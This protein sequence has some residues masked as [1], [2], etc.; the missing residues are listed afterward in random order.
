[1]RYIIALV[2][3]NVVFVNQ[4]S[5]KLLFF[6]LWFMRSRPQSLFSFVAVIL[7]IFS[8]FISPHL[9]CS[10][11]HSSAFAVTIFLLLFALI[12]IPIIHTFCL[13]FIFLLQAL[14]LTLLTPA[15]VLSTQPIFT[16]KLWSAPASEVPISNLSQEDCWVTWYDSSVLQLLV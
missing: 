9:L 11:R 16:G 4:V 15:I 6:H 13:V 12:T 3:Q 7:S 8:F 1:M 2:F 5:T 10:S 14:L